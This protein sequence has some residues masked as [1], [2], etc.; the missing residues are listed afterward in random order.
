MEIAPEGTVD[1]TPFIYDTT[2]YTMAGLMVSTQHHART[3]R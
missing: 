3:R 2:M 1:P